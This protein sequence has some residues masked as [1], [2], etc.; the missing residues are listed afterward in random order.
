[1]E[2]SVADAVFDVLGAQAGVANAP[3]LPS[4]QEP[5]TGWGHPSGT[6]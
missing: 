6:L 4:T 2:E 1:M 5:L 3:A